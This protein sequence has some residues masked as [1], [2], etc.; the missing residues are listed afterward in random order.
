MCNQ[1]G[2]ALMFVQINHERAML[3]LVYAMFKIVNAR[4]FLFLC[5]VIKIK[6]D[7]TYFIFSSCHW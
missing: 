2:L 5:T 7:V 3:M 1:I 6:R 4:G